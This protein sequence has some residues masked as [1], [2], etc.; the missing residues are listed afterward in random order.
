MQSPIRFNAI[1]RSENEANGKFYSRD[2]GTIAPDTSFQFMEVA[3]KIDDIWQK[4][5]P[6]ATNTDNSPAD[7]G[8][9]RL[10]TAIGPEGGEG[11]FF[12][13]EMTFVEGMLRFPES[14]TDVQKADAYK[15]LA[16]LRIIGRKAV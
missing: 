3:S 14:I 6:G 4:Y 15:E 10:D 1:F 13:W 11:V 8:V 9:C 12:V 5:T 7:I 2:V 16:K